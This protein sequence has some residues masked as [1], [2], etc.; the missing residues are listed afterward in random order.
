M[1]FEN[2]WEV[3]SR[4]SDRRLLLWRQLQYGPLHTWTTSNVP[5]EA[6]VII[7]APSVVI[8]L[9]FYG[10]TWHRTYV[11]SEY[12]VDQNKRPTVSKPRL[13]FVQC[14]SCGGE[15][16]CCIGLEIEFMCIEGIW[17]SN[18]WCKMNTVYTQQS[19]NRGWVRAIKSPM[20]S[21]WTFMNDVWGRRMR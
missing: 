10:E 3:L 7:L 14:G 4:P 6:S 18:T 5:K 20:G 2:F 9:H 16:Q 19:E 11:V 15:R 21:Q 13:T 17:Y 1:H 8:L 12:E